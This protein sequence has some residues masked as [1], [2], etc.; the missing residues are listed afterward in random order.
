MCFAYGLLGVGNGAFCGAYRIGCL[1][2]LDLCCIKFG[3]CGINFGLGCCQG[4]FGNASL[5]GFEST[6]C[7]SKVII[8]L[9][10]G[11][12]GGRFLRF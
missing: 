3:L 2:L 11:S 8:C 12:I 7:G 6:I 5:C 10:N 4:V 9:C 1:G